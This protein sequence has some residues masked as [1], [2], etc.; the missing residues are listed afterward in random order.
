MLTPS[1]FSNESLQY[2]MMYAW[3]L[4]PQ[5]KAIESGESKSASAPLDRLGLVLADCIRKAEKS[6]LH[7]D[8]FSLNET[9]YLPRGKLELSQTI[10][11]RANQNRRVSVYCDEYLTDCIE[12]VALAQAVDQILKVPLDKTTQ[13]RLLLARSRLDHIPVRSKLTEREISGAA[14]S[15]RRHEYK[16]GLS[17]ALMLK[18]S[19]LFNEKAGALLHSK[20]EISDDAL[21]RR[22][23]EKFLRQYYK[24][25]FPQK[26]VT[27]RV[28]RW[29]EQGIKHL[30]TMQTDINVEGE[31]D[32]IVIDAKCTPRILLGRSDFDG[33]SVFNSNHLYQIHTYMSHAQARTPEKVIAG[34]LIYPQYDQAI[35]AS[36]PTLAGQLRIKTIDF[37]KNWEDIERQLDDVI[38]AKH[39]V[40]FENFPHNV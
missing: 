2:M 7:R 3:E 39:E 22:L 15:A 27:G 32:L 5:S 25:K 4:W 19:N 16:L 33:N 18:K 10:R 12:N 36:I 8:Y 24:F 20:A 37:K 6:G 29:S 38:L 31:H 28:Y 34:A 17:I 23:Y 9:T 21:F 14:A 11:L 13:T 40:R 26:S 35:D 1:A 30:P